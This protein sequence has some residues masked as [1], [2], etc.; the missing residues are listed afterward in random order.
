MVYLAAAYGAIWFVLF[1]FV[2]SIFRRQQQID[3]EIEVLEDA[4]RRLEQ[5]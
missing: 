3:T 2:I 4:L 5:K 1:L